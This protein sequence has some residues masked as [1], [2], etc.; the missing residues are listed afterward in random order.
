MGTPTS[1]KRGLPDSNS[2]SPRYNSNNTMYDREKPLPNSWPAVVATTLLLCLLALPVV[3]TAETRGSGYP[4][5]NTRYRNT[6]IDSETSNDHWQLREGVRATTG[7]EVA[8]ALDIAKRIVGSYCEI[9]DY[10]VQLQFEELTGDQ[11]SV[12]MSAAAPQ[13]RIPTTHERLGAIRDRLEHVWVPVVLARHW[14]LD[15]DDA[16]KSLLELTPHDVTITVNSRKRF[17]LYDSE[18]QIHGDQERYSLVSVLLHELLHGMGFVSNMADA[19][20]VSLYDSLLKINKWPFGR[21][22]L[23]ESESDIPTLA[24]RLGGISN[25]YIADVPVYAP[26]TGYQK[27]SSFHHVQTDRDSVMTPHATRGL[28]AF[29]PSNDDIHILR[30]LGWNC[31]TEPKHQVAWEFTT[32][33]DHP[34]A[35]PS[36]Y[37]DRLHCEYHHCCHSTSETNAIIALILITSILFLIAVCL[38]RDPCMKDMCNKR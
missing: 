38:V 25:I 15:D 2:S 18:C 33:T 20:T 3:E 19:S 14:N 10:R 13:V 1:S 7:D 17:G 4:P 37:H 9:D 5:T 32:H 21:V 29:H 11:E 16:A 36:T 6:T 22:Y 34:P 27:G 12:V 35:P 24:E 30:R 8:M 28:C 23:F 26:D 31:T